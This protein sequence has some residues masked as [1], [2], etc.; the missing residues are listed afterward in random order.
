MP[1]LSSILRPELVT[2]TFDIG[3]EPVT[4]TWNKAHITLRWMHWVDDTDHLAAALAEVIHDWD[5]T[6]NDG[7][8]FPPTADNLGLLP[9]TVINQLC[10]ALS[11]SSTPA[12][13]EGK[14]SSGPSSSPPA[15]S[16]QQAET[17]PNGP[18][19]SLSLTP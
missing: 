2:D 11:R 4:V 18:A 6:N 5:V 15:A 9:M 13:V 14:N 1:R 17:S 16:T 3:G 12:D 19:T 10:V 7:D 8:P